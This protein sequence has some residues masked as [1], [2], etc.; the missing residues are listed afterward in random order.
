MFVLGL[1]NWADLFNAHNRQIFV[2]FVPLSEKEARTL[3]AFTRPFLE[4]K[5]PDFIRANPGLAILMVPIFILVFKVKIQMKKPKP[6]TPG[7]VIDVSPEE[8][9]VA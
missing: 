3:A 8:R 4:K 6:G 1:Q 7:Q 9:K 5:L 2:I